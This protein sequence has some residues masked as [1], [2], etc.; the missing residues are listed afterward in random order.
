M[1]GITVLARTRGISAMIF[2]AEIFAI[3]RRRELRRAADWGLLSRDRR[4]GDV[5]GLVFRLN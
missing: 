3:G 5:T 1:A 2:D 4:L